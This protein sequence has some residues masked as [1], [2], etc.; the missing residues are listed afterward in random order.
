MAKHLTSSDITV[1]K[2]TLQGWQGKLTW[3]A[4]CIEVEKFIGKKPS[5]QSLNMH[6]D[7]VTAYLMKKKMIQTSRV[8]PK[9]PASL[10]IAAQRIRHIENEM[11]MLEQQNNR[12]KEQFS[13]WQYN[14]N[15]YGLKSHQLNEPLPE[16]K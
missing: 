11:A 6:K 10:K 13:L 16:K 15:K 4:L 3:E 12:Y 8:E 14:A 9:K 2:K 5:R 7:I 1:I